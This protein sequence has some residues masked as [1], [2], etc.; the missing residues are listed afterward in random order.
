MAAESPIRTRGWG[1]VPSLQTR[2]RW[3]YGIVGL[4]WRYDSDNS[5]LKIY[6]WWSAWLE[7]SNSSLQGLH[8]GEF[9]I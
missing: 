9:G 8:S 4:V 3:S 2:R 6:S 1:C 5:E 7:G